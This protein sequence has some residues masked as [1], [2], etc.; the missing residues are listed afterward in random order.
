MVR[1]AAGLV[2][3]RVGWENFAAISQTSSTVVGDGIVFILQFTVPKGVNP[4]KHP[5]TKNIIDAHPTY[6]NIH[7]A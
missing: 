1:E 3:F 4:I 7:S 6:N 2:Y 5:L